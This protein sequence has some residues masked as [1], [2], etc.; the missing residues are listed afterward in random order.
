MARCQEGIN[1]ER[2]RFDVNLLAI[3][4]QPLGCRP[5]D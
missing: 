3:G 2:G 4:D 5:V 1:V